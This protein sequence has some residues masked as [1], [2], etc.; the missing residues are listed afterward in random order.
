MPCTKKVAHKQSRRK[1][2]DTTT[3]YRTFQSDEAKDRYEK[4]TSERSFCPE[5][6]DTPTMGYDE[7]KHT[8]IVEHQWRQF[9][10]HPTT[11]VMLL[12]R[13]FYAHFTREGQKTVYVRGVQVPIDDLHMEFAANANKT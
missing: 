5:M 6:Q 9:C 4:F 8:V 7:F 12:V 1:P 2:R 3:S 11:N 13:E 10:S